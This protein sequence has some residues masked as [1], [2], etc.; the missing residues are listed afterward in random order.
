[1]S[2]ISWICGVQS[3]SNICIWLQRLGL[4]HLHNIYHRLYIILQQPPQLKAPG[5]QWQS[6]VKCPFDHLHWDQIT[7][8][9]T[10]KTSPVWTYHRK[11]LLTNYDQQICS[12][13]VS[14]RC[15]YGFNTCTS[16]ILK[17][18]R[19]SQKLSYKGKLKYLTRDNSVC[20]LLGLQCLRVCHGRQWYCLNSK[21]CVVCIIPHITFLPCI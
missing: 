6:H 10:I 11:N 20:F 1:M 13:A 2:L 19:S 16:R 21:C 17:Q 12:N 9:S 14:V 4:L 5:L 18:F 3:T 8:V 15:T 7:S